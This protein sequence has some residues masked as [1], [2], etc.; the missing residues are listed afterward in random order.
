MLANRRRK[1]LHIC[2]VF[3]HSFMSVLRIRIRYPVPVTFLTPGSGMGEKLRSVS[4]MK[5]HAGSY[6]RELRN[7]FLGVYA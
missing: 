7:K 2:S 4:V 1:F 6:C 3:F 5:K